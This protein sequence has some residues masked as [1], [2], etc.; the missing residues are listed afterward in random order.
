VALAAYAAAVT[1]A[2]VGFYHVPIIANVIGF[3]PRTLKETIAQGNPLQAAITAL[4]SKTEYLIVALAGLLGCI[5][6]LVHQG[7]ILAIDD[8]VD[9][10]VALDAML[11]AGGGYLA[12]VVDSECRG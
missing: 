9:G 7:D 11:I 1:A 2:W 12:K 3:V 6:N 4:R 10:E 8:S 5:D